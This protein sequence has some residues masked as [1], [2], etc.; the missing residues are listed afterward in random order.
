MRLLGLDRGTL[1]GATKGF[2]LDIYTA[3]QKPEGEITEVS[4]W[5]PKPGADA[6]LARKVSF[7]TR[8]GDLRCGVGFDK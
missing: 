1:E 3:A 4:Y 5:F 6:T 8:V 2:G 7:L